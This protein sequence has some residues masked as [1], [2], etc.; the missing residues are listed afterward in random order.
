LSDDIVEAVWCDVM[1]SKLRIGE[2]DARL[3]W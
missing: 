3:Q 1:L 2:E